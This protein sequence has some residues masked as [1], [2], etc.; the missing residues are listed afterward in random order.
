[1]VQL[2]GNVALAHYCLARFSNTIHLILDTRQR[3]LAVYRVL[4]HSN[5]LHDLSIDNLLKNYHSRDD[6]ITV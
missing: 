2:K 5:Q 6:L 4:N 3:S 1:M